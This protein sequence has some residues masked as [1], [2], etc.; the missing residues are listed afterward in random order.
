MNIAFPYTKTS[1]QIPVGAVELEGEIVIPENPIGMVIF[2]HGSG[3]SRLSPRNNFVAQVLQEKNIATLLIDLLTEDEDRE[4]ERRFNIELLTTRLIQ[5]THWVMDDAETRFLPIGYFG[6]STGAA[7]ALK[8]AARLQGKVKT[9]VSR[10]GRPDLAM[11]E[12]ENVKIPVLLIVGGLDFEVINL[13]EKA[14]N[15]LRGIKRLEIIPDATHLFEEPGALEAVA[16]TAA[17][18]FLRHL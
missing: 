18:W 2:S 13:N 17:S 8:A 10:G 5:I 12:L 16:D 7:S 6:A 1:V 15:L 14:Y 11:A 3:S 9:V 4:Y